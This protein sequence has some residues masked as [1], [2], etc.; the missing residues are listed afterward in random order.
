MSDNNT[1]NLVQDES[2]EKDHNYRPD[3]RISTVTISEGK[4]N[5]VQDYV[6]VLWQ[7]AKIMTKPA[8]QKYNLSQASSTPQSIFST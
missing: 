4:M 5:V 6:G 3:S 7:N 8:G 1:S 2:V